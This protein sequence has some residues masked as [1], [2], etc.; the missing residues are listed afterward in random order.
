M[1]IFYDVDSLKGRIKMKKSYLVLDFLYRFGGVEQH[2][3]P[4]VL[5][6]KND[7]VLVD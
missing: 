5:F 4:V 6:G 1:G 7:V 3:F 2:L